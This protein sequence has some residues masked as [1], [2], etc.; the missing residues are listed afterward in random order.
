MLVKDGEWW[1]SSG[2]GSECSGFGCMNYKIREVGKKKQNHRL[3]QDF[4]QSHWK[5]GAS[6]YYDGKTKEEQIWGHSGVQFGPD[7]F[8]KILDS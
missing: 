2:G 5:D 1:N 8:E 6:I 3:L 7:N 4:V